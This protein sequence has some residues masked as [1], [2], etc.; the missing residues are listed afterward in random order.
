M[1]GHWRTGEIVIKAWTVTPGR[2]ESYQAA[3]RAALSRLI[4][5]QRRLLAEEVY[6]PNPQADCFWCDFKTLCPLWPE[7]RPV[8]EVIA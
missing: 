2:E 5:E 7:G 6:R 3:V 8:F 1:K 4:A